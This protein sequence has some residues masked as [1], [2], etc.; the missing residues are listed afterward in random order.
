MNKRIKAILF[1]LGDTLLDF[2]KRVEVNHLF[3]QGARQAYEYLRERGYSLPSFRSYHHRH[4]L[5]IRW[6]IIKSFFARRDFDSLSIM[7]YCCRKLR[8]KLDRQQLIELCW[9]WYQPLGCSAT[10]EA[11]LGEML[12]SLAESGLK[13]ALVSNTF[14][15]AEVL[16]RHLE[17]EN[18]LHLL[19]ER[20]YSC[21]VGWRKPDPR[22]FT[23]AL[24]RLGVKAG[25]TIF[26]G[27]SLKNDIRGANRQGMIS[28]LKDPTGARRRGGNQPTHTI[29]SI[30]EIPAIIEQYNGS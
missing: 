4:W 19:P 23:E 9:L 28:V 26:V 7:Q 27:D 21:N 13:I 5:A 16:D 17:K 15:P 10:V 18:L 11:G 1:D 8:L 3:Q 22:I 30:L 29:T 6:S 20:I 25:E 12:Q 14:V 24:N 2:P